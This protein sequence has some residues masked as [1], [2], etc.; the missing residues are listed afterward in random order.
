ML[1]IVF[2]CWI[3]NLIFYALINLYCNKILGDCW[4]NIGIAILPYHCYSRLEQSWPTTNV[5]HWH[6]MLEQHWPNIG[7]DALDGAQAKKPTPCAPPPSS[8]MCFPRKKKNEFETIWNYFFWYK[9]KVE[10]LLSDYPFW[11]FTDPPLNFGQNE[12]IA[13]LESTPSKRH[14]PGRK[15]IWI[16]T[17]F[18]LN[19]HAISC[20]DRRM[21]TEH[22][23][24]SMRV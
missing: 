17:R 14:F 11:R 15:R 23:K 9:T 22:A 21:F 1:C 7:S 8:S 6:T 24:R 12:I 19:F 3:E 10:T 16:F 2:M 18:V 13:D 4:S 20:K 5:Q